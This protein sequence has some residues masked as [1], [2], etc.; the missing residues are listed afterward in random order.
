MKKLF[1]P[2]TIS[3][4]TLSSILLPARQVV[5]LPGVH[6]N[7]FTNYATGNGPV[8]GT[9]ANI[10]GRNTWRD[11]VVANKNDNTVTVRLCRDAG[12]FNSTASAY[13]VDLSPVAVLGVDLN[14]DNYDDVVSAN[15]GTNTISVLPNLRIN[16]LGTATNHVVG[17][18]PNPGPVALASGDANGSGRQSIFVANQNENTVT[19]LTNAG[20][21]VLILHSNIAVGTGPTGIAFADLN[22]D[23]AGD[24]VTANTN[25]TLTVLLGSGNGHFTS[26]TNL[27]LFPGGD[28]IPSAIGTGDFNNDGRIDLVTANY[29]SNSIT[30]LI[31]SSGPTFTIASN[32]NVGTNPRALVVRD[33]NRD[34]I[35]DLI[36][37]N[38]NSSNIEVFLG[39]GAGEFTLETTAS[40]GPNPVAVSASNFNEDG[41]ND[42]AVIC[43]G[44]NTASILLY[45]LPVV[46]NDTL[47]VY[48]DVAKNITVGAQQL[49]NATFT[50]T[51]LNNPTHGSL[52]G[53]GPTYTYTPDTNYFG[54]DSFTFKV[55]DGSFDSA[56]ATNSLNILP[57]NDAPSFTL[58]TNVIRAEK[59]SIQTI[60]NFAST[61]TGA[62]N[63]VQRVSFIT[64]SLSASN[65][66][67]TRPS[68]QTNGTLTFKPSSVTFGSSTVTVVAQDGGGKNYGGTNQSP[69]QVF[70][71]E[72]PST[73]PFVTLKG[74]YSGIFSA[75]SGIVPASAGAFSF[76][77]ADAGTYSGSISLLGRRYSVLGQ[78][79]VLGNAQ[80]RVITQAL[81]N[82]IT[83]HL[84]VSNGTDQVT[85]T[86]SNDVWVA[87]VLGDKYTF[88]SVVN[89]T[90]LAGKYNLLLPGTTGSSDYPN[91]DSYALI[92]VTTAGKVTVAGTLADGVLSSAT[93]YLSKN[94]MIPLYSSIYS[95][96]G[97]LSGW[98]TITNQV[99]NTLSGNVTWGTGDYYASGWNTNVAISGSTYTVPTAGTRVVNLT[100]VAIIFRDGG[101]ATAFT[102][103][104]TLNTN[105]T[106]SIAS[107]TNK[108]SLLVNAAAGTISGSFKH[109]VT[110][111]TYFLKG[112]VL[113]QQEKMEGFFRT[114]TANGHFEIVAP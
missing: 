4:L 17:S 79:D 35:L 77:L 65:I 90:P 6:Y 83:L 76:N 112:V 49:T 45:D 33:V 101:L 2:I 84:D 80:S 113:Q 48:E 57:V 63:E 41:M 67:A 32:Y 69:S 19:V 26:Y 20:N 97:I 66:F 12:N 21:C 61:F 95:G 24:L 25:G 46:F 18:T 85:G 11:L 92:T 64:T 109:P 86:I 7:W 82:T 107:N 54:L 91:G 39:N 103:T 27:T 8:G 23:L 106:F 36:V 22:N 47:T 34:T 52:T 89:P 110:L 53:S 105:N 100:N 14:R 38:E 55:N 78:F 51:I 1:L 40:V 81:T 15:F 44:D 98:I 72:N 93:G 30:V 59:F 16:A 56:T 10:R 29:N 5:P 3:L 13:A 111:Q 96:R 114:P 73:N 88:D 62:S 74:T 58:A 68:I 37:A 70:T 31:N 71:I 43:N 99:T 108:I 50:Y 102:N 75:A 28:P 104:A 9:L 87:N 94:G 60:S 42:I